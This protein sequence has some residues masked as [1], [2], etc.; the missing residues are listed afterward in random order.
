VIDL[1]EAGPSHGRAYEL[2]RAE[3]P[4]AAGCV[5]D[6]ARRGAGVILPSHPGTEAWLTANLR[7]RVKEHI[8]LEPEMG[9]WSRQADRNDTLSH[10]LNLGV[11]AIVTTRG[12]PVSVWAGAGLGVHLVRYAAWIASEPFTEGY[13]TIALLTGFDYRVARRVTLDGAARIDFGIEDDANG[14]RLYAGIR[15]H[16]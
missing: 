14:A 12:S 9:Y 7:L 8:L 16:F 5:W 13:P 3:S 10:V 2:V 15:L 6:P 4:G 1:R 11:N